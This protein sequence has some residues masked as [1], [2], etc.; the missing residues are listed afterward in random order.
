MH[1]GPLYAQY[2]RSTHHFILYMYQ[3]EEWRGKEEEVEGMEQR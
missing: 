2:A 1:L 3:V